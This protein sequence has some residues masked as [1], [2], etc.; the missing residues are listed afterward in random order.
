M[1]KDDYLKEREYFKSFRH[2]IYNRIQIIML[3]VSGSL[4][5]LLSVYSTYYKYRIIIAFLFTIQ[6]VFYFLSLYLSAQSAK[7]EIN[8]LDS[9]FYYDKFRPKNTINKRINIYENITFISFILLIF[10]FLF[11][12]INYQKEDNNKMDKETI[13]ENQKKA[14][15]IKEEPTKTPP[16]LSEDKK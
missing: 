4:F 12:F 16:T 5:S 15:C 1:N 9:R 13:V 2:N 10:V 14:P 7:F 11:C 8:I 3:A 6:I